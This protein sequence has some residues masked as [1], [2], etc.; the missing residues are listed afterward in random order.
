MDKRT[1]GQTDGRTNGQTDGRTRSL[2]YS[3]LSMSGGIIKDLVN[4]D[5]E[6][7]YDFEKNNCLIFTMDY[8]K[9]DSSF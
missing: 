2:Q 4:N 7:V 6:I 9:V 1:D 3:P 5:I 8:Y